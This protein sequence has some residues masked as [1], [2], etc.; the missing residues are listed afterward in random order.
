MMLRKRCYAKTSCC[1]ANVFISI[2]NL[3]TGCLVDLPTPVENPARLRTH[4]FYIPQ[5]PAEGKVF[6]IHKCVLVIALVNMLVHSAAKFT[7]A[8]LRCRVKKI[9]SYWLRFL[10][11]LKKIMCCFHIFTPDSAPTGSSSATL[12]VPVFYNHVLCNL[13]IL[14]LVCACLI[15]TKVSKQTICFPLKLLNFKKIYRMVWWT[16]FTNYYFLSEIP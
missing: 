8:V 5:Q 3:Q 16:V 2:L 1:S 14:F 11:Y 10:S 15:Q 12:L 9:S 4:Q 6:G 7:H 13:N